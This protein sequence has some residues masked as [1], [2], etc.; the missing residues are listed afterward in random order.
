MHYMR[1]MRF[2]DSLKFYGALLNYFV[3]MA[4]LLKLGA[5][6]VWLQISE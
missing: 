1:S 6:R 2:E 4:L 3:E 5:I